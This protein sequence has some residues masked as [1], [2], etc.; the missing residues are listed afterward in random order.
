VL[1]GIRIRHLNAFVLCPGFGFVGQVFTASILVNEAGL[2][3]W[4]GVSFH[5]V[6]QA[7]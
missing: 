3:F 5:E 4:S 2:A 6:D 1:F 7:V